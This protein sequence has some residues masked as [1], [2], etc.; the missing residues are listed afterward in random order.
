MDANILK[1]LIQAQKLQVE[2][3][4]LVDR[5]CDILKVVSDYAQTASD[6]DVLKIYE[7]L[8]EFTVDRDIVRGILTE[9]GLWHHKKS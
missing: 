3:D 9:R 8:P 6:A 4:I 7:Y 1:K 2:I 5:Q